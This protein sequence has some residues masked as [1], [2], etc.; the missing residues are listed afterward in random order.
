MRVVF[1]LVTSAACCLITAVVVLPVSADEPNP[2]ALK[3]QDVLDRM[4]KVYAG[5]KSY[6]DSGV[7]KTVFIQDANN[8]T[9]EKPFTTAFVRPDRFRFEYKEKQDGQERRYLVWRKGKEVQTWW[10]IKPGIE[11][12]ESLDL[13]LAGAT[14]VSGV[15]AHTVPALL[16]PN[17]VGGRRLT[18]MTGAKRIEDAKLDKVDCFRIEGKY[19]DSPMTLWIDKKTF[20]VRRIDS[21]QKFG[22]FRTE[23]T[24]TYDPV[25]D[26]EIPDKKLEFDPPKEK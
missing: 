15:S 11:K 2:E 12:P 21:Q 1:S 10:D 13:A 4:A 5:C 18:D 22:N 23:A 19:A 25:T 26:D 7:V 20:L 6:R 16:L 17:E 3:A 14:G 8:H 9:V 24:T